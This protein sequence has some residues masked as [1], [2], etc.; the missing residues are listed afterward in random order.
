MRITHQ[1]GTTDRRYSVAEEFTGKAKPQFVARFCGERIGSAGREAGA[2]LLA[3]AHKHGQTRALQKL[4]SSIRLARECRRDSWQLQSAAM[5]DASRRVSREAMEDARYW[6]DLATKG[7]GLRMAQQPKNRGPMGDLARLA[8]SNGGRMPL[9]VPDHY[10]HWCARLM[11]G[12][13]PQANR[14]NYSVIHCRED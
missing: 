10:V 11:H 14:I 3:G 9:A 7:E 5:R 2:W 6:R 4:A 12:S 8:D 13:R 1:D